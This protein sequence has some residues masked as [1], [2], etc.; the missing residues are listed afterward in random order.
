LSALEAMSVEDSPEDF[1]PFDTVN[2]WQPLL[3]I[4]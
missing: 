2:S 4:L 3:L 1:S